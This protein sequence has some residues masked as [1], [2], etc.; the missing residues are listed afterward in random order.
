MN[1]A[2]ALPPLADDFVRRYRARLDRSR[3]DALAWL[4]Y[5]A[6]RPAQA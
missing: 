5:V 4:F 6:T 3:V 1:I 2:P